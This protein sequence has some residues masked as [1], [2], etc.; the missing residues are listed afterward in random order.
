M[1]LLKYF[2]SLLIFKFQIITSKTATSTKI[3]QMIIVFTKLYH[4][5]IT[6]AIMI[7]EIH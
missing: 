6:P 7:Q 3:K 1:L 2:T 5:Q 4:L